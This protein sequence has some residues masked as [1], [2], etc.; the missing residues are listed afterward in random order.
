MLADHG[1]ASDVPVLLAALRRAVEAEFWCEAEK[2]ACGLG[3]L[4]AADAVDDLTVAWESTLHSYAR[5]AFLE[6]LQGCAGDRADA[7]TAEALDDCEPSV[8]ELACTT[9]PDGA[10]L[11]SRIGEL[12]ED[13]LTPEVHEAARARLAVLRGDRA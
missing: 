5:A 4:R 7:Y 1:D 11:R 3:R 8:Q 12:A 9:A 13:P 2:P 6:G 10:S